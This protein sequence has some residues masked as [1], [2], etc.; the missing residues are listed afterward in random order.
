M[1]AKLIFVAGAGEGARDFAG[2]AEAI[3]KASNQY[4]V[5]CE[6]KFS[7]AVDY[8]GQNLPELVIVPFYS[9]YGDYTPFWHMVR[10]AAKRVKVLAWSSLPIGEFEKKFSNA[11]VKKCI[12]D[13]PGSFVKL[14]ETVREM[15]G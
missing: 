5:V 4:H 12:V 2:G 6:E 14:V 3:R 11:G 8:V 7:R 15:V 10:E 13:S 9:Y 1:I